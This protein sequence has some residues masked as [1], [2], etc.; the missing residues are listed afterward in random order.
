MTTIS[1]DQLS[2]L[3]P[4]CDEFP[5][6]SPLPKGIKYGDMIEEFI[7]PDL[8]PVAGTASECQVL[9][10]AAAG[11]VG[12][13]TLAEALSSKK[14]ALIWDLAE[15]D[16]V[17]HGTL[18]A[19]LEY[20]MKSGS[21]SD[22][23]EWMSE[24]L[25]FL[26]IDALDEG[27]FKVT[28]NAFSLLLE[29]ISRLAK[30]STGACF[31]LFGRTQIAES[32]WVELTDMGVNTSVVTIE[33]FSRAQAN[34]YVAKRVGKRYTTP[35]VECR[36]LIFQ[37]LEAPMK[38]RPDFESVNEFLHYPPVLDVISVLL[39][40]EPNH[41]S[42]KNILS[43]RNPETSGKLIRG[44]MD[45]IL[46][47]EHEKFVPTFIGEKIVDGGDELLKSSDKLY[48]EL[49]Q[50]QR[51][52][53]SVLD[54][55][56][57]CNPAILPSELRADYEE[58][59]EFALTIH[60]FVQG[61]NRFANSVF[62]SYLYARALR[63]DFGDGLSVRVTEELLG[64]S[65]LAQPLLAEFY[66]DI[67]V[68]EYVETQQVKPEHVGLLYDSLLS[69]ESNRRRVRLSVEGSDP[70]N[71]HSDDSGNADGEFELFWTEREDEAEYEPYTLRFSVETQEDSIISFR[72]Y[73]RD[74]HM[75]IPCTV[76]LGL[77]DSEFKIGPSV[78]ISADIIRLGSE[79][80]V[81]EKIPPKYKGYLDTGV[82][83]EANQFEAPN[84]HARP[85]VFASDFY[86]M[87]RGTEVYP[88]TA[89]RRDQIT[90]NF[91]DEIMR[92]AYQRF[93]RFATALQS[94][95]K[96]SL[97]RTKDK[98]ENPRIMQG[99]MGNLLLAQL[100]SDGIF[101][102]GDGGRRYYWDPEKANE[103]LGVSWMDLR[104][105][106]CPAKLSQYL[107]EFI[108]TNRIS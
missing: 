33:P 17:G 38:D 61:V 39:K 42:L 102:L 2:A 35:M 88:W 93:R 50:S 37:Q 107:S 8:S 59:I 91:D 78:N 7:P 106:E 69:S 34:D 40:T 108:R 73:I 3:L 58:A 24:G 66:F 31:V 54:V 83:L 74:I 87:G 56:L 22:F 104:K 52:L 44:M 105:G 19:I 60:P 92:R 49:E 25:Q 28:E 21:K 13:S 99:D 46:Q 63:G 64:S 86:V 11:A 15:G 36:D 27:R 85:S 70:G 79:A 101:I 67:G 89:Y 5:T 47:R 82:A 103:L 10:V 14:R 53:A 100:R 6:Q 26:I 98:I 62:Q 71:S 76:E 43:E 80:L 81:V 68:S 32:V 95:G 41:I 84:V 75:T 51:L 30:S 90:R 1:F 18:D 97:A 23:L 29:N 65:G 55:S 77:K 94:R 45:H 9:I 4:I 72:R 20:T 48:T 57:D 12:K 96:G 16:D